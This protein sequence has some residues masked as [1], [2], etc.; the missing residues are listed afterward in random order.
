MGPPT[1]SGQTTST[2]SICPSSIC[3]SSRAPGRA[4]DA[5]SPL[6]HK[7]T[8]G[9]LTRRSGIRDL[10]PKTRWTPSDG[11]HYDRARCNDPCVAASSRPRYRARQRHFR[12]V[13]ATDARL[14]RHIDHEPEPYP[15]ACANQPHTAACLCP[16]PRLRAG[17]GRVRPGC[18]PS[19]GAIAIGRP[20]PRWIHDR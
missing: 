11:R 7:P 16:Q 20:T 14:D 2:P 15:H 6:Q 18:H 10:L 12:C 9:S 4:R 17:L 13:N 19:A 5:P 8:G 1:A 3:T